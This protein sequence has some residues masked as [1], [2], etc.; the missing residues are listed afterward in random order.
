MPERDFV[1][2]P[3]KY[4][5]SGIIPIDDL[6]K[7]VYKWFKLYSYTT[8]T[9]KEHK[10]IQLVEGKNYTFLWSA[11][12]KVSDYIKYV[13]D[14]EVKA[15][16]LKEVKTEEAKKKYYKGDINFTFIA[17]L[18]KDYEEH[19]GKNPVTKFMR[20]V[21]DKYVTESKLKTFEKELANERDKLINEIKAF[22]NV[23]KLKT[24]EE[25]EA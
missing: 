10:T 9:E 4:G 6:Y 24:K 19:Y 2:E 16:G 18:E 7:A 20:E 25:K 23:Q 15:K 1:G 12:K 5:F 11:S 17:Y 8:V 3:I 22:L 21:Y 14:I 13:L